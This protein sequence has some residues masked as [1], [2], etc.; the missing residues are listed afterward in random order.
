MKIILQQVDGFF[1]LGGRAISW[2]SKKQTCITDS[3]MASEFVALASCSKEAEWL[4]NRLLEINLWPKPMPPVSL[5]CDSEATLSR[6]YSQIY[7]GKSRHIGLRHSYVRQLISDGVITIDFVKSSQNLADPLTKGLARDLV[8][9]T[10]KGMGLK[11][12]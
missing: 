5:H 12:T 8:L 9:K 7:N 1:T 2:G 11:P 3:T 6:A 10:S 4:R